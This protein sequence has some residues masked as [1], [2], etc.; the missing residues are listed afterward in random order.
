VRRELQLRITSIKSTAF[1]TATS[2]GALI[3]LDPDGDVPGGLDVM[4]FPAR[5][6]IVVDIAA[7]GRAR[8]PF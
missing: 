4:D 8:F 3:S 6:A 7:T 5:G 1:H 2:S